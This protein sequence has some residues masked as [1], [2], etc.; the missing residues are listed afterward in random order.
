MKTA[1][2]VSG[3]GCKGAFAVG[4]VE[5]L[6]EIGCEFDIIVGTSTGAL[7]APLIGADKLEVAKD[8][9]RN[10]T[11]S[12]LFKPYCFLTLPW[13]SDIYNDRGLRKVI[14]KLYTEELHQELQA[15]EKQ[16]LACTV[17]L[18]SGRTCYWGPGHGDRAQFCRA[19][20]ASANQPGLMPPRQIRKGGDY[21]VDGG[22]REIAP[23]QK[24]VEL[25]AEKV[26]A[27]ILEQ[28]D[29]LLDPREF[30]RIPQILLRTLDLM[31]L[32]T[33]KNDVGMVREGVNLVVIRPKTHLTDNSLKFDPDL[34]RE[35]MKQGYKRAREVVVEC[36]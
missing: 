33:R 34:M 26:Y 28:E 22:V 11:T 20:S 9:Y 17:S 19:L 3:G 2:V 13:R 16:V 31:F 7:I 21:H 32:E 29:A 30:G 25:G 35:M 5:L 6:L 15:S 24:A 8:I 12:Q 4:A 10:V 18:N 36:R 1:L 14:D 27:I 23:I